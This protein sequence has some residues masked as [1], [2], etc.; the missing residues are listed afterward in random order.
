MPP[1]PS[2]AGM[3]ALLDGVDDALLLIDEV[4]NLGFCNRAAMRLLGAEPGDRKSVV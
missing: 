3:A 1:L 4:G 2:L